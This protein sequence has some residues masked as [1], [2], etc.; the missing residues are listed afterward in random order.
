MAI[1]KEH[2]KESDVQLKNFFNYGNEKKIEDKGF[3]YKISKTIRLLLL[4]AC[5]ALPLGLF[6]L[7]GEVELINMIITPSTL[8]LMQALCQYIYR[9]NL[10]EAEDIFFKIIAGI[11][12][13]ARAV[14]SEGSLTD[15]EADFNKCIQS[16][17]LRRD[18]KGSAYLLVQSLK[19]KVGSA[20]REIAK[21]KCDISQRQ[22]MIDNQER[23]IKSK[24]QKVQELEEEKRR[25]SASYKKTFDAK[26][27]LEAELASARRELAEAIANNPPAEVAEA[28]ERQYVMEA[29]ESAARDLTGYRNQSDQ[30]GKSMMEDLDAMISNLEEWKKNMQDT[31][32]KMQS[33]SGGQI[34]KMQEIRS[35]LQEKVAST[36]GYVVLPETAYADAK[37]EFDEVY[38]TI[39]MYEN[40]NKELELRYPIHQYFIYA[41]ELHD[42]AQESQTK[43]HF[44]AGLTGMLRALEALHAAKKVQDELK[45]LEKEAQAEAA[46]PQYTEREEHLA[47]LRVKH[48][49]WVEGDALKDFYAILDIGRTADARAIKPA[50]RRL[51]NKYHPD[52]TGGD[53]SMMLKLNAALAVLE[54]KST[55]DEYN[56]YWDLF[57]GGG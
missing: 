9:K 1:D 14:L 36:K 57:F 45:E 46:D 19:D 27:A 44:V 40:A 51:A 41:M 20:D 7:K 52:K 13:E 18:I 48:P 34:G 17:P 8:L 4:P 43:R 26:K 42:A 24:N 16:T 56:K 33:S 39:E 35:T 22:Q 31:F 12:E 47:T 21:L 54:S 38:A 55:R 49:D 2:P 53:N 30:M 5:F 6:Q 11:R 10:E 50:Y 37:K 3:I 15:L 32:G 25:L 28:L 23:I 29:A